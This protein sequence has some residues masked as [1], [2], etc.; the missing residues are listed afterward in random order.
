[1]LASVLAL[2]AAEPTC[3]PTLPPDGGVPI[4][5]AAVPCVGPTCEAETVRRQTQL[6]TEHVAH[7]FPAKGTCWGDVT[8]AFA[9]LASNQELDAANAVLANV[10][11]YNLTESVGTEDD[12]YWAAS[13]IARV[14]LHPLTR[15]R[16]SPGARTALTTLMTH[17]VKNR[18]RVADAALPWIISGSENHDAMRKGAYLLYAQLLEAAGH[19]GD[20]LA[21][22]HTITEHR[23]AWEAFWLGYFRDRAREGLD[24]E[25]ASPTY[26]QYGLQVFVN[27]RDLAA[28]AAVRARAD[29]F[30]TLFWA[31]YAQDFLPATGVRGGGMTR[32]YKDDPLTRGVS[33][34]LRP[35]TWMY[36]WHEAAP[37][38]T[39]PSLLVAATSDYRPPAI[40]TAMTRQTAPRAYVSRRFGQGVQISD[41]LGIAYDV[42][43]PD[44]KSS[45]R[46]ASWWTPSYVMGTISFDLAKPYIALLNQNRALGVMFAAHVD[47][48]IMIAGRGTDP[49]GRGMAEVHGV[50]APDAM[51]VARD[52]HAALSDGTRIFV[53]RGALWDGRVQGAAWLFVQTGDA[54]AAI[55]VATGSFIATAVPDGQMLD[56]TDLWSP[57]AIQLGRA[58]DYPTLAAFRAAV[59]TQPFSFTAGVATY[60]S[61][62]GTT[63]AIARRSTAPVQLAG[64]PAEL[65]PALTYDSPY[66]RGSHGADTVT[67]SAPGFTPLVL[68][69]AR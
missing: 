5:D 22:G 64:A 15:P 13:L 36:G 66:L 17:F 60:R 53:S 67:L 48:R 42:R 35:A 51:L 24:S 58:A 2:G 57:V 6:V 18:S 68:D 34:G 27:L 37:Q 20:A 55:R 12:C 62:A 44:G 41:P 14:Q 61:L 45:V 7:P 3:N 56:L 19:G 26:A 43:F 16:L 11:Q 65:D 8:W 23:A 33:E 10:T 63:L 25:I 29:Q 9:A 38:A 40:V 47:D 30:L 50:S 46:R 4:V 69:F 49:V 59:E 28:S 21:D 52:P 31:D 32:V 1:M 54:Y 39:N